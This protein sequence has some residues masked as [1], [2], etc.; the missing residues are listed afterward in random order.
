MYSMRDIYIL[1]IDLWACILSGCSK[2][3]D[4]CCWWPFPFPSR[5]SKK[6]FQTAG[7]MMEA[8]LQHVGIFSMYVSARLYWFV[9][10]CSPDMP[11]WMD[12]RQRKPK[13]MATHIVQLGY[14]VRFAPPSPWKPSI[15]WAW[16]ATTYPIS[17]ERVRLRPGSGVGRQKETSPFCHDKKL[18]LQ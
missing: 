12:R 8:E 4:P 14:R 2:L 7:G 18:L 11:A 13:R 16:R 3:F 9:W 15:S 17:A 10:R 6:E 5:L 1:I